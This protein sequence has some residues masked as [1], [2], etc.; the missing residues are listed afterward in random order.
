MGS[1]T[2][3]KMNRDYCSGKEA[4]GHVGVKFG[5]RTHCNNEEA[6]QARNLIR[7]RPVAFKSSNP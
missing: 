5:V 7:H 4:K 3:C 2:K 6:D 1:G